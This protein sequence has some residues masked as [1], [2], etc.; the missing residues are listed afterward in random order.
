MP[1]AQG[2]VQGLLGLKTPFAIAKGSFRPSLIPRHRTHVSALYLEGQ[3][4]LVSRLMTPMTQIVALV[5]PMINPLTKSP[6]SPSRRLNSY[7]YHVN[8][9]FDAITLLGGPLYSRITCLVTVVIT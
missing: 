4:D 2:A 5:N 3:G 9:Y 1:P 7:Q 6:D 8:L